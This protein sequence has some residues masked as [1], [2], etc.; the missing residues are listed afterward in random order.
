MIKCMLSP[1]TSYRWRRER[2][3]DDQVYALTTHQLQVK[4]RERDRDD[5]VY[6]LTTHQLQVKRRERDRDDQVSALTTHQQ[7]VERREIETIKCMRSSHT[8]YRWRGRSVLVARVNE[9]NYSINHRMINLIW[10]D[11]QKLTA[12]WKRR[13]VKKET[14]FMIPSLRPFP[15]SDRQMI[16]HVNRCRTSNWIRQKGGE[17][18]EREE[19]HSSFCPERSE[20]LVLR[21]YEFCIS[22]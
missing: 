3:R 12:V 20:R 9:I 19:K 4:R 11:T 17:K 22:R 21:Q 6:A 16:N 13:H 10:S 7:Q 5:Q 15:D 8:S 1:H 14:A 2:H 18:H